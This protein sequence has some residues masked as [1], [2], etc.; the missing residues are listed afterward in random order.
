MKIT[1]WPG[2]GIGPEVAEAAVLEAAGFRPEWEILN[3][4]ASV[5]VGKGSPIPEM[6][7]ASIKKNKVAL[8]D[9]VGS[10]IGKGFA[11]VN[12][13]LR[14]EL[15]LFANVRPVKSRP[16]VKSRFENVDMIIFRE[17]T[18]GLYAG[19]EHVDVPGVVESIKVITERASFRMSGAGRPPK[20]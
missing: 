17:N 19:I 16:G 8:K 13:A 4:G 10:P 7:M 9:P 6:V 1:L 5:E 20:N 15:D 14:K 12:V 11:L 3:I 18:E 2:D